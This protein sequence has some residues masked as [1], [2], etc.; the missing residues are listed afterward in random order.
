[1]NDENII[2]GSG[3]N[4]PKRIKFLIPIILSGLVGVILLISGFQKAFEVDLFIR[5][6]RDYEILTNPLL[7]IFAAWGLI[8]FECCLGAAL[9]VNFHP[10]IAVPAGALLFLLFIGATGYAWVTGVTDD[11]G[12][13]GSWIERTPQEAMLEDIIIFAALIVALIFNRSYKPW[14]FFMKEV[15]TLLV[16]LTGLLLPVTTG[17]LIDRISVAITGPVKEGFEPF[18]LDNFPH[19]DLSVGRHLI[20]VLATDCS[21]CK[22]EMDNLNRIAEDESLPDVISVS[23]NNQKQRDK[24]IYDFDSAFEIYQIPNDDFW[25]LLGDGEIPRII[26]VDN[27]VI[28]KKWDFDVPGIDELK[29]VTSSK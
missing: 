12:C 6:M 22:E 21:H 26:Y 24:F 4:I 20:I 14:P 1:M 9:L 10:K 16:L 13:F 28:I 27:G 3:S 2:S 18:V 23:M 7:I 17:P 25:R 8:I 29:A 15:L 19:K 11:C 5:Q